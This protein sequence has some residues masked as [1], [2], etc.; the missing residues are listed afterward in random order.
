MIE[1]ME[2]DLEP[3]LGPPAQPARKRRAGNDRRLVPMIWNDEERDATARVG[4]HK[5]D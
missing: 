1:T 3:G 5:V 4:R 2:E